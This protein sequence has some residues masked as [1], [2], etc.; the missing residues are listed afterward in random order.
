MG[1]NVIPIIG[2][3]VL[4][5]FIPILLIFI[6]R[7]VRENRAKTIADFVENS[8]FDAKSPVLKS[9]ENKYSS[10]VGG[11]QAPKIFLCSLPYAL[12]AS[13]GLLISFYP[14]DHLLNSCFDSLS[15]SRPKDGSGAQSG[16]VQKRDCLKII[17]PTFLTN[18]G[19]SGQQGSFGQQGQATGQPAQTSGQQAQATSQEGQQQSQASGQQ[20]QA[21]GQQ[22]QVSARQDR[23]SDQ[24]VLFRNVVTIISYAFMG[25][26]IF[27]LAYLLR[28][29]T[30]FELGPLSFLRMAV[31]IVLAV[32]TAVVL[33]RTWQNLPELAAKLGGAG[34]A[35]GVAG[36]G[37]A[38][39]AMSGANRKPSMGQS[40]AGGGAVGAALGAGAG[41]VLNSNAPTNVVPDLAPAWIA[42]AFLIGFFPDLG[43]RYIVS[44]V[45]LTL[46]RERDDV[47][48][49]S[50]A[51][52]VEVIDGIDYA[53]RIR[54]EENDIADVQNLATTNPIMLY[55]ETPFQFLECFD[56]VAQA[57][58]CAAVGPDR[59][60]ELRRRNI[61][62]IFDLR[63]A[64]LFESATPDVL[65][66]LGAILFA[67]AK[68]GDDLV[69]FPPP[70]QTDAAGDDMGRQPRNG[71]AA[72]AG[73]GSAEGNEAATQPAGAAEGAASGTHAEEAVPVKVSTVGFEALDPSSVKHLVLV[74]TNNLHFK[75]LDQIRDEILSGL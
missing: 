43:L 58:L 42:I 13:F 14:M 55:V 3:L 62:T 26:F 12:F 23:L 28:A 6:R 2:S 74:M 9:I 44:R 27:S 68:R 30:N 70:H 24:E 33:W 1:V 34:A 4:A 18:G 31:Q 69:I 59:F 15:L 45:P 19:F 39:L 21:S 50:G 16:P 37:A 10:Q 60:V 32:L 25:A 64:V 38:A 51:T 52:S 36:G 57:Q 8:G 65:K 73:S 5:L 41:A 35:V 40:A 49:A 54:L 46:K 17:Q 29:V 22:A 56:W 75:R 66:A 71:Q 7:I 61:R 67:R 48:Q 47:L 11:Y 20:S 72:G 53:K 63:D